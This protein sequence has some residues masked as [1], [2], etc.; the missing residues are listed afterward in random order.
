MVMIGPWPSSPEV[1]TWYWQSFC[2]RC[3]LPSKETLPESFWPNVHLQP[4]STR[5]M[6]QPKKCHSYPLQKVPSQH[7]M[8]NEPKKRPTNIRR[9]VWRAQ[10]EFGTF[11]LKK[12]WGAAW[13]WPSIGQQKIFGLMSTFVCFA[14]IMHSLAAAAADCLGPK[15]QRMKHSAHGQPFERHLLGFCS[16]HSIRADTDEWKLWH[17]AMSGHLVE[18]C[19]MELQSKHGAI[20]WG[21]EQKAWHWFDWSLN[22]LMRD[23]CPSFI[24]RSLCFLT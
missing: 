14:C 15:V 21:L 13:V 1:L 7:K 9:G 20:K 4:C 11:G 19:N 24:L 10:K 6:P 5:K 23:I 17:R 12:W 18:L 16:F 22:C 8:L 2:R 3:K